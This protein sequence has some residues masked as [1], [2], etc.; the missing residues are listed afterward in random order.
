MDGQVDGW[1]SEIVVGGQD[2]PTGQQPCRGNHGMS[3]LFH[4]THVFPWHI[5]PLFSELFYPSKGKFSGFKGLLPFPSN[6]LLGARPHFGK[7]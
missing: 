4:L 6:V 2:P 3:H 1:D 7:R 5:T